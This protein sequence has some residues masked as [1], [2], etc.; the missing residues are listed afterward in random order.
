MYTLCFL[1]ISHRHYHRHRLQQQH[2]SN[3]GFVNQQLF[4]SY[5]VLW[6][7]CN[8]ADCRTW[9]KVMELPWESVRVDYVA[10][11]I[12]LRVG[13]RGCWWSSS[14]ASLASNTTSNAAVCAPRLW[15]T[16]LWSETAVLWQD[17]SQT[18]LGL[19]LGF[20]ALVLVLALVLY[21]WSCFHH[22][23]DRQCAVWNDNAEM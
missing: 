6:L 23:C 15:L 3:L 20:A 10:Y 2:D 19:G 22:C 1:T 17:Q 13:C 7:F 16:V 14:S 5:R 21:F 9:F 4:T 8:N 12:L 18:G 11:F